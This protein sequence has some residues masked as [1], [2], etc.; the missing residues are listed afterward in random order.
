MHKYFRLCAIYL[1]ATQLP[2]CGQNVTVTLPIRPAKDCLLPHIAVILLF[3]A[4]LRRLLGWSTECGLGLARM[5]HSVAIRCALLLVA[6]MRRIDTSVGGK[7]AHAVGGS[8]AVGV[9]ASDR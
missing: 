9:I 4:I 2:G 8:Q 6:A 1:T 5:W 7:P 3:P